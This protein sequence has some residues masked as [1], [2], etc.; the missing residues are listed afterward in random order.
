[1][2][3]FESFIGLTYDELDNLEPKDTHTDKKQFEAAL[4]AAI[5]LADSGCL[6]D[7]KKIKFSGSFSGH[8]NEDHQPPPGWSPDAVG[9]SLAQAREPS[10]LDK[11][12]NA[13]S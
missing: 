9:V 8:A 5:E 2:S 4:G 12:A 11:A 1:M 6:G 10:K 13:G 7:P 3:W